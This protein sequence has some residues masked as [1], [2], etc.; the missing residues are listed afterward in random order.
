MRSFSERVA[1]IGATHAGKSMRASKSLPVPPL[2]A[3]QVGQPLGGHRVGPEWEAGRERVR[4]RLQLLRD[5]V[6]AEVDAC[7]SAMAALP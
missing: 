5:R 7:A 1:Q 3:E 6:Q 2:L 4:L